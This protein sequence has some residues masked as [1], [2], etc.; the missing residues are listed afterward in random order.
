MSSLLITTYLS[1]EGKYFFISTINRQSS[2][3]QGPKIYA[4]TIVWEWNNKTRQR[5][6]LLWQ[7]EDPAGS[8]CTHQT[9]C[10]RLFLTGKFKDDE[11]E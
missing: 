5:G 10:A 6:R 4:E 7:D 1:H 9:I 8:I 2:A 11:D 3:S